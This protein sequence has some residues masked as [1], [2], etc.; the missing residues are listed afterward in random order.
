MGPKARSSRC[1]ADKSGTVGILLKP[2][3]GGGRAL[4][5]DRRLREASCYRMTYRD[6]QR[7]TPRAHNDTI[8]AVTD[9]KLLG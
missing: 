2:P 6:R 9:Q 5:E 8:T 3:Q 7:T 4:W 1:P